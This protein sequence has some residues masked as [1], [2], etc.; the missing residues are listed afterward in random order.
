M[1]GLNPARNIF[2]GLLLAF[3]SL[4]PLHA[5][6]RAV[7]KTFP[8]EPGAT[9]KFNTYRGGVIVDATDETQIRVQIRIEAGTEDAAVADRLFKNLDLQL[10]SQGNVVT[11]QARN[12]SES[13]AQFAWSKTG[14]DLGFRIFV[15]RSCHVELTTT[16]GAITVGEIGGNLTAH[17]RSG[18]ISC[19]RA[20]GDVRATSD[21]GEI[22]VSR[23]A[24]SV[25]L[26]VT[27]GAIRAGTIFG[28]ARLT[29]GRGEIE[30][31]NARGA[32]TATTSGGD[33]SAGF[34]RQHRGGAVLKVDGGN[35]FAAIDPAAA[36]EVQATVG[37][38]GQII[39]SL[40]FTRSPNGNG[41]RALA[42]TLNGG[43]P[44]ISFRASGGNVKLEA[45]T[46]FIE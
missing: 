22:V 26:A 4:G 20:G 16:D 1:R 44:L 41:K 7:E 6:E 5:I 42:G 33:L 11:V 12:P 39:T 28:A 38:G 19:R 27:R 34:S 46:Q 25:D 35:I 30:I 17:S 31:Q 18:I 3:G 29:N 23:C 8:V 9:L 36:C 43:G 14:L 37:F 15:P 13:R 10:S 24:G 45:S 2:L 21:T 32:L 40:P